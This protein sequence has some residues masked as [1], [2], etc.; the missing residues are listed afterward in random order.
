MAQDLGQLGKYRILAEIGKGGFATVYRALDTTLDREVALKL[1]DPLLMRDATWVG[2]FHREARAVARL[3]HPHIVTIHEI[4]EAEGRLYIAMELVGGPSLAQRIAERGRLSW[5][6][7]L[8][9]LGQVADALDYAHGQGVL[10]RDLKPG[11]ILLDPQRGPILTDFGFARL[12]GESSMSVSVSGGVV[13]TPAYIAPEVWD[14]EEPTAATDLYALGCIAY[15]MLTGEVLFSGKTPSVVMRKHLMDGPQWPDAAHWPEGVPPGVR[16]ILAHVLAKDSTARYASAHEFVAA[17][18]ASSLPAP[19]PRAPEPVPA[20]E[21][22]VAGVEQVAAYA[23]PRPEAARRRWPILAGA[24]AG[25]AALLVVIWA[26]TRPA[27]LPAVAYPTPTVPSTATAPTVAQVVA[28]TPTREPTSSPAPT[29]T[30]TSPPPTLTTRPTPTARP[31]ETATP[32]PPTSTLTPM[33]TPTETATATPAPAF[34]VKEGSAVNVRSGP[35]TVYPVIGALQPGETRLVTGRNESAD[36]WQFDYAG[37]KGWVSNL[38]V[39]ANTSALSVAVKSTPLPPRRI[40][41]QSE[42]D[43]NWEIYSMNADGSEQIRLTKND[44]VDRVPAWSPDGERIAFTSNRDDNYEVYI[45][46]ADGSNVVRLTNNSAWDDV[47]DW[48]PDGRQIAFTSTRDGNEEIYVMNV[49]GS[50]QIRLTNNPAHDYGPTWSPDGR[51]IAFHSDR[52]GRFEIYVMKADGSEQRNLTNK[53]GDWMPAWSPDGRRIAFVSNRDGNMEIYVMNADGSGQTRLTVTSAWEW[54]PAWSSDGQRI[55]FK[56]DRDG[57]AEIYVMNADGSG[58]VN[59]TNNPAH[60]A[61]PKW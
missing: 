53:T 16:D 50:N 58:Q 42:R 41:F 55:A 15:E 1:L 52:S 20:R 35:G 24:M 31:T 14:G 3:K 47:P 59:L 13:G 6:E 29:A 40:L 30:P 28:T 5:D 39:M 10:H 23:P 18:A 4:A 34:T 43:G 21:P 51:Y 57:N 7:T 19:V 11:N 25:L 27:S 12:V 33:E 48:S 26:L 38:V 56:S 9:I 45:M 8:V 49:D 36:W 2:R 54:H 61:D 60:D 17:L 37:Q 44:A 46:R 22:S 32:V